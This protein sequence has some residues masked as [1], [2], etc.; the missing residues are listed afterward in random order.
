MNRYAFRWASWGVALV[1]T[2]LAVPQPPAVAQ[3]TGGNSTAEAD[4]LPEITVTAQRR[5][6]RLEDVG[7]SITAFDTASME[8]LGLRSTTD[9]VQQVPGMQ[10]QTFS[11]TITIF[12]LRG[13]SQNDFGDHHEAPVAV[14]ADD[15]YQASM[16][17][18]AGSMFDQERVEVLRGPQGTL[19]GR[20]AT[21]GLIHYLSVKPSL[22]G[23]GGYANLSGGE[24]GDLE[25]EGAVN[26]PVNDHVGTRFSFATAYHNGLISNFAGRD[27]NTQNQYAGRFQVLDKVSDAGD[28]LLKLYYLRNL[29]EI[30]PSYAWGASCNVVGSGPLCP[31]GV[32]GLGAFFYPPA[33]PY[34]TCPGCDGSGYIKPTSNPF[35]QGFDRQGVFYR[36]LY[37]S[38]V[39]LDWNFG[40]GLKLTSVT[41]YMHLHKR[42]GEDSDGSPN[43]QFNFDTY[44]TYHQF[45]E[46][47]HLSDSSE[48]FRWITGAYYLDLHND[49]VQA[50]DVNQPEFFFVVHK[51]GNQ[52]TLDT[53]SW[54]LFAQTEWDFASQWT[55]IAGARYTRDDKHY[56]YTLWNPAPGTPL[57]DANGVPYVYNSSTAPDVV[58]KTFDL[59]SGKLELDFKPQAG[60][61]FYGSVNRGPKGGGWSAPSNPSGTNLYA[62]LASV[63][64]Y[65]PETLIDYEIGTKVTFLGGRG[66]LNADVFYYDYRNYQAF[67]LRNFTQIIGNVDA[68][69]EGGEV[70]LAL[71]PVHG[72][73]VELGVAAL[74]TRIKNV[75]L[76]DGSSAD[77]EM[78]N[79]P[80]WTVNLLA[81][82]EWPTSVGTFSASV[83]GKWNASQWLENINAPVD[84]QPSYAVADVHLGYAPNERLSFDAWAKNV[85]NKYYRV[86][87][88]DLSGIGYNE[89][90]Y[91]SPRWVGATVTYR[92]GK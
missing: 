44:Q 13:I 87:N 82:Y 49:D 23:S 46:E 68:K 58:D 36:T 48:G 88:L 71:I 42:Y 5:E 1:I 56:N 2:L 74:A 16:S 41:D 22:D 76:P 39:H 10:Y 12:N 43:F 21:G 92:F 81:R 6:Q 45:S 79:A 89:S 33:N 90:V 32:H 34:G 69:L 14:Y 26:L 65:K 25:T 30:S 18:V 85:A 11:P 62:T 72:L 61:L 24:Y 19:F 15:V 52:F 77:R 60:L 86:Y 63:L 70:E 7:T 31:A 66:R 73:T 9:I 78:P 35:S 91:G 28:V 17:S 29:G 67:F 20:N 27:A 57:L 51:Q 75:I 50:E 64:A 8:K 59:Y 55:L 3:T 40:G 47:L 38:T 83:D 84:F 54:A 53:R 4:K 37:G 80:K